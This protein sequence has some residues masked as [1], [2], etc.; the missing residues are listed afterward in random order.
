MP[1]RLNNGESILHS[2]ALSP[3]V[4]NNSMAINIAIM[5]GSSETI[6]GIDSFAPFTKLEYAST[7]FISAYINTHAIKVGS[8]ISA[9]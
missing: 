6:K 9:I 8:N 1:K 5:Y 4:L 7:F 2:T 3:L